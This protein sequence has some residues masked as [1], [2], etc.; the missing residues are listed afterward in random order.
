MFNGNF[1]ISITN[2]YD[3]LIKKKKQVSASIIQGFEVSGTVTDQSGQPL[4]GAS[5]LE[6]GTNNGIQTDFDGKYL[7]TVSNADAVLI[8]SY[9]GFTTQEVAVG[10]KNG[11]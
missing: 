6:K 5:I 7:L 3:I 11:H 10:S 9:L 1:E 2:D 4:P 8:I